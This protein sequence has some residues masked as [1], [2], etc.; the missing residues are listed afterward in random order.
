M[1]PSISPQSLPYSLYV[2]SEIPDPGR[3]EMNWIFGSPPCTTRFDFTFV[4]V[5]HSHG[6]LISGNLSLALEETSTILLLHFDILLPGAGA[7]PRW[8]TPYFL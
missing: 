3:A 5:T 1:G 4:P 7:S 6:I 8:A 2:Y